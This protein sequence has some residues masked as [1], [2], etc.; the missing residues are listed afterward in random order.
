[1]L[2]PGYSGGIENIAAG[3]LN[4]FFFVKNPTTPR[5]QIDS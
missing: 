5:G 3:Y 1:M 4:L 2:A